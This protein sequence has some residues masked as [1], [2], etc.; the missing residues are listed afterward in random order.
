MT[1]YYLVTV[2][3]TI[4]KSPSNYEYSLPQISKIRQKMVNKYTNKKIKIKNKHYNLLYYLICGSSLLYFQLKSSIKI[5]TYLK[6]LILDFSLKYFQLN[7]INSYEPCKSPL[8]SY[9]KENVLL[10]QNLSTPGESNTIFLLKHM[11]Q[12]KI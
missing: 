7:K 8:S 1:I 2:L 4:P 5:N 10:F 11:I 3:V 12:K 9:L 6:I